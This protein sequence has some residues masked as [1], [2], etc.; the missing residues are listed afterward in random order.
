MTLLLVQI[1]V[2]YAEEPQN[3]S[4][5]TFQ[6]RCEGAE[7]MDFPPCADTPSECGSQNMPAGTKTIRPDDGEPYELAITKNRTPFNCLFL[8]EPIGGERGYDL[9]KVT[10]HEDGNLYEL[11]QGEAIVGQSYGPVQAVL[12][13]EVG[14]EGEGPFGLLYNYL[15]LIYNFVSGIIVGFAVLVVI[16]GGIMIATSGGDTTKLDNGKNF[17]KK[18]L[19]GMILWFTASVILY[20]INPT[21]FTF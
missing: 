10:P 8:E 14:H 13:F 9:F 5:A 7:A 18:A 16:I 3:V 6:S 1:I 20:T 19:I 12:V 15:A 2:V 4:E 21:F 11:W 17:I